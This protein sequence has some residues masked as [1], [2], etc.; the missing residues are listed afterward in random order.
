[1]KIK[2][3]IPLFLS[4]LLL[5]LVLNNSSQ[6]WDPEAEIRQQNSKQEERKRYCSWLRNNVTHVSEPYYGISDEKY[7]VMDGTVYVATY[8]NQCQGD[9]HELGQQY[10]FDD[11][12]CIGMYKMNGPNL[13]KYQRCVGGLG[14][15]RTISYTFYPVDSFR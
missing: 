2:T 10:K 11:G 15:P 1:M 5:P 7:V 8:Y 6:A 4:A 12:N 9:T 14:K 13:I 3:I